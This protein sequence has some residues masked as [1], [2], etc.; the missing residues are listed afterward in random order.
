[1]HF[2]IVDTHIYS[3]Y[4]IV[5]H[6]QVEEGDIEL[7]FLITYC[8]YDVAQK[9]V[10]F[11]KKATL[12]LYNA[13]Q[14]KLPWSVF[15]LLNH[16]QN[17]VSSCQW[18]VFISVTDSSGLIVPFVIYYS[19]SWSKYLGEILHKAFKFIN[20]GYVKSIHHFTVIYK[21]QHPVIINYPLSHV[22]L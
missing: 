17:D 9:T 4:K 20:K 10:C 13:L 19:L 18:E 2:S 8:C 14:I 3:I 7:F 21:I 22:G 12:V 16:D 1:M 5:P 11:F 6:E 15:C